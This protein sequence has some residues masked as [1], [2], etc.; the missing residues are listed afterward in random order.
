MIFH[1]INYA[2]LALWLFSVLV[3]IMAVDYDRRVSY[4]N[5]ELKKVRVGKLS[6]LYLHNK[7][8]PK[9]VARFT[10]I[11][12]SAGYA[13]IFVSIALAIISSF[14]SFKI[15]E[16]LFIVYAAVLFVFFVTVSIIYGKYS[17]KHPVVSTR[18]KDDNGYIESEKE[19]FGRD[20][21][22]KK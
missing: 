14:F 13:F 22:N 11:L 20:E 7:K 12:Q 21:L 10:F 9:E 18:A 4:E 19:L 17:L 6:F 8:H 16:I 3:Y 2:Y 1:S 15:A 5:T